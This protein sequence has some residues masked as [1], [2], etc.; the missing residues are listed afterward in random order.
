MFPGKWR[1]LLG[2]PGSCLSA[3]SASVWT[4]QNH[5][6]PVVKC[7]GRFDEMPFFNDVLLF[8]FYMLFHCFVVVLDCI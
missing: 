2:Q 5:Q 8:F 6:L 4:M 3:L 7:L 1:R